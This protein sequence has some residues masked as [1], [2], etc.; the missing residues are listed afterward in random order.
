MSND[1]NDNDNKNDYD[2]QDI[3][4]RRVY[5]VQPKEKLLEQVRNLADNDILEG[6]SIPHVVMTEELSFERYLEGWRAK[7]LELCKM[8]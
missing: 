1:K 8:A 3:P 4:C 7:I 6:I 5:I 2:S